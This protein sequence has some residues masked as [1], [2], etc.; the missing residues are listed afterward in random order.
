MPKLLLSF[1]AHESMA[2]LRATRLLSAPLARLQPLPS[3]ARF[4]ALSSAPASRVSNPLLDVDVA[5]SH[6]ASSTEVPMG[7]AN[8]KSM[9]VSYKKLRHVANLAQGL[10]WREA[11]MQ[12]EFC[13][14]GISVF[15]K[16]GINQAVK[17]A[18]ELGLD[19]TRL[20]VAIATVGKGS[21]RKEL[22][23]KNKGR[24][25]MMAQYRSHLYIAVKE[26]PAAEIQRTRF[27]GRWRASANLL[28]IPWNERVA[29]LPRY[30]PVVGYE[31]G[32]P[33]VREM[34]ALVDEGK[35]PRSRPRRRIGAGGGMMGKSGRASWKAR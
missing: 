11:M 24:A 27:Y 29:M 31:P 13:S 15:V 23:F 4:R 12:L 5:T 3:V 20:V 34:L 18:E 32:E 9:A 25:G 14:K 26:V 35:V 17:S 22:Q 33:R 7:I 28:S 1:A 10:Y 30:Q 21:Y 2:F 19:P 6:G 16:N 8:I